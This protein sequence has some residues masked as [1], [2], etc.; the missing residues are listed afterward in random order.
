[1]HFA[2]LSLVSALFLGFYDIC[3]KHAL[4]DNP[5]L[6]VL[7]LSTA[8]SACIWSGLLLVGRLAPGAL[9]PGL[10]VPP[11]GALEHG[12]L[13]LKSAIVA[14]SWC[15]TY[16]AVK[17]LPISLAAPIRA[18]SPLWTLAA[19]L[20][21]LGERPSA[22]QLL[23]IGTTLLSFFGLSVVGR[24]EGV[25]FHKNRWVGF[26]ILGT[27]LAAASGLYD[28]LLLGKLKLAPA[29]V[30]AWFSIYLLALFLPLSLLV[31][32]LQGR[33]A[34]PLQFRLSIPLLAFCLLCADFA[35]FT[36]LRDPA[37]LV[38]LVSSIRRGS[39]LIAFAAGLFIFKEQNGRQKLGPVLGI[40]AGILLTI[41]G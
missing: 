15:C 24:R 2:V 4:R 6:P 29:T 22:L 18:T 5:V 12:E 25:H 1:M 20:V 7:L 35:Y 27:L 10:L 39:T 38:S 14:S 26:M 28:K 9:P 37:G 33:G 21:L 32:R 41:A 3:Q 36:A 16:L 13:L 31:R 17:H 19:A 34:T 8:T 40:V 11:L 23:G 30:Q